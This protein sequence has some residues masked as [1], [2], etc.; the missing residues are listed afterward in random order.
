MNKPM[1]T[2][3]RLREYMKRHVIIST[4]ERNDLVYDKPHV[5]IRGLMLPLCIAGV[6]NL[7]ILFCL[8][9]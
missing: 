9:N 6:V 8:F 1:A 5:S 2:R 4:D 3:T 7:A